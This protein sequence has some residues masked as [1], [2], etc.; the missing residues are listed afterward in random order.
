MSLVSPGYAGKVSAYQVTVEKYEL[1]LEIPPRKPVR[2]GGKKK[3]LAGQQRSGSNCRTEVQSP[4]EEVEWAI[5]YVEGKESGKNSNRL[6]TPGDINK[7]CATAR[8]KKHKLELDTP[9]KTERLVGMTRP[10]AGV[11]TRPSAGVELK[12]RADS[13]ARDIAP[14]KQVPRI[15]CQVENCSYDAISYLQSEMEGGLERGDESWEYLGGMMM[16]LHVGMVHPRQAFE[17][18]EI[19]REGQVALPTMEKGDHDFKTLK[20]P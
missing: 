17:E 14:S 6:I 2:A 13:A 10:L 5:R 3:L 19:V 15:I 18:S 12:L 16:E 8:V 7:Y 11:E 1:E 9:R 4:I 20:T